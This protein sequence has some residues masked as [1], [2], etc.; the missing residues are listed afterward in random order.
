[1]SCNPTKKDAEEAAA[2]LKL[3]KKPTKP[4]NMFLRFSTA[5][6]LNVKKYL[7]S[8]GNGTVGSKGACAKD[9]AHELGQ[10]WKKLTKEQRD[11]YK[12]D[13]DAEVAAYEIKMK[14]YRSLNKIL[15]TYEKNKRI[16][17]GTLKPV[18]P[19]VPFMR[20]TRVAY[21][22]CRAALQSKGLPCAPRDVAKVLGHQWSILDEEKKK[23]FTEPYK[24]ERAE[25]LKRLDLF[26]RRY[27]DNPPEDSSKKRKRKRSSKKN[28]KEDFAV[29][30]VQ[31]LSRA[32]SN[33]MS[34]AIPAPQSLQMQPLYE[35][36]TYVSVAAQPILGIGSAV[37]NFGL[38]GQKRPKKKEKRKYRTDPHR[39]KV[40]L[41][42]WFL[43][44]YKSDEKRLT[45]CIASHCVFHTLAATQ[46]VSPIL[47]GV[48]RESSE[49]ARVR[50][51]DELE[52][53]STSVNISP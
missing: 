33:L 4:K 15:E 26:R 39:P 8:L 44:D 28:Q 40:S 12:G 7:K 35:N 18:K 41:F 2:K 30:P 22:P 32:H 29:V 52:R 16:E 21:E 14:E 24:K 10:R 5:E 34:R 11:A 47:C 42:A 38:A 45:T 25:Y 27:G 48:P 37:E 49:R 17:A 23:Q 20:Y 9:V 3:M 43:S 50:T 53:K 31:Q 13:Y 19:H 36:I 1:M 46:H 6:R 51:K